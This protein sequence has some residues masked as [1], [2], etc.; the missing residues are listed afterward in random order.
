MRISRRKGL[1]LAGIALIGL[2]LL[3]VTSSPF[4]QWL[5]RKAELYGAEA[6]FP[7]T[8][9]RLRL[10]LIHLRAFVDGVTYDQ[11]GQRIRVEHLLI[12]LPWRALLGEGLHFT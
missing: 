3:L 1:F 2:L 12:D 10:E 5:L 11:N 9:E 4:Q 8:A 7:F 6:G